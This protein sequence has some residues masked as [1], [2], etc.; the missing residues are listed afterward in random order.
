VRAEGGDS[1][2]AADWAGRL[3]GPGLSLRTGPFVYR[4]RSNAPTLIE[5]LRLHYGGFPLADDDTFH[6]FEV[7]LQRPGGLRG[8]WRPQVRFRFDGA[9]TFEPLPLAHAFPL[10]EW[11]MNWCVS[12]HVTRWLLLH[13]AV[14]EKG[15]RAAVLPAPPG[16]GKSTLCAALVNRGWRLLSD[17]LALVAL[18]GS[19]TLQAL[20]RPVSLKNR[21]I[22]IIRAFAPEA[23]F[24]TPVPNTAKGTVGHMR[25]PLEHLRRV[26]EPTQAAWVV[27]PRW[28]A[29]AAPQLQPRERAATVVE[30]ARNSFNCGTL[31]LAGFEAMTSLV[32]SCECFDFEY[33]RLDDAIATFDALAGAR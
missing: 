26:D 30:L 1:A 10:L 13:A 27:F 15:G 12:A 6:D 11:A 25:A 8:W 29:D 17:E 21:S 33:G 31:G 4:L 20:A 32:E 19:G 16:S 22:E 28:R 24:N 23:V 18:D 14:V 7:E 3:A 2:A 9:E 5:P